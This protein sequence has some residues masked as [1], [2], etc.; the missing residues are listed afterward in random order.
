MHT[1][2]DIN[3]LS[4]YAVN[5]Q[6]ARFRNNDITDAD[7]TNVE[8]YFPSDTK[9]YRTDL[10]QDRLGMDLT[11]GHAIGV[12]YKRS[13]SS[14]SI[15]VK[16]LHHAPLGNPKWPSFDSNKIKITIPSC[17]NLG[18]LTTHLFFNMARNDF[19]L[20]EHRRW[21]RAMLTNMKQIISQGSVVA[22][23]NIPWG[24][25]DCLPAMMEGHPTRY[26][27]LHLTAAVYVPIA[28]VD[29]LYQDVALD[30]G[31]SSIDCE[32]LREW[33]SRNIC[34]LMTMGITRW[35]QSMPDHQLPHGW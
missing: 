14:D 2:M 1:N 8:S 6:T 21:N 18:R 17:Y 29:Q 15:P 33:C 28:L 13:I 25:E 34:S 32:M 19:R 30:V 31:V 22:T 9:L 35:K 16:L 7:I 3:Q 26:Y 11:D 23:I 20:F 10:I 4:L 24:R 12:D 5:S 27:G